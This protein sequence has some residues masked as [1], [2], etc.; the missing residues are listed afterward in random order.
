[1]S[2]FRAPFGLL[3]ALVGLSAY[4]AV[5]PA[6]Y[7]RPRPPVSPEMEV[8][9][10]RFVQVLMAAGDRFLA[11]NLDAFRALVVSTEAMSAGNYRILGIVQSDAAWLNPAQED[12]YYIAA[13]ILPWAGEVA[14]AQYILRQA[15]EARPFDTGPPFYYAFN[16]LHFLNNPVEGAKWLLIAA[17]HSRDEMEQIQLQQIAALWAS[18]GEDIEF[19]IRLHRAMARDTRHKAFARFLEKRAERLENLLRLDRAIDS[20]R[21]LVGQPPSSLQQLVDRSILPAIPLDP[22]LIPYAI[23]S[24]GKAQVVQQ[25][26]D[27]SGR[28]S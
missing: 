16:E 10:P 13:A 27:G 28:G 14:A 3:L 5:V 2:G 11:A 9:L 21:Q 4:T 1:M 12:N 7:A 8:A 24:K 22:F 26:A 20:Y 6:L 19:S 17:R 23:D 18:K 15:T 25:G